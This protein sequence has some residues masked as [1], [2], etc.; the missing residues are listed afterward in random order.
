MRALFRFAF[1]RFAFVRECFQLSVDI[2][3]D[4]ELPVVTT[5]YFTHPDQ[6]K[7]REALFQTHPLVYFE[8][9]EEGNVIEITREYPDSHALATS[10][11][12]QP[13]ARVILQA[14]NEVLVQFA[15]LSM[16][17][18]AIEVLQN[19]CGAALRYQRSEWYNPNHRQLR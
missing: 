14:K 11:K 19:L 17:A 4:K 8:P 13:V 7:L 6:K 10:G 16:G 5:S 3:V 15:T 9:N 2:E 12:R 18:R 1:V